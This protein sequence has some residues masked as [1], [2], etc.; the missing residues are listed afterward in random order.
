MKQAVGQTA[1]ISYL[2]RFFH[3]GF[4]LYDLHLQVIIFIFDLCELFLGILKLD[5]V[6]RSAR[7]SDHTFPCLSVQYHSQG[8]LPA[9]LP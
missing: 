9:F 5:L 2:L 3:L 4:E 6:R 7:V 1:F 8:N